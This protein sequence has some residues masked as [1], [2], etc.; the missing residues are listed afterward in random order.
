MTIEVNVPDIG[1]F[2]DV[3]VV[4]ILVKVGDMISVED[5]IIELESDKAT[6]EVPSPVAGKVV[7]INVAEGDNVSEGSLLM[8]VESQVT[9]GAIEAPAPVADP[10]PS[11]PEAAAAPATLT[12]A[13]AVTD[14]GPGKAHASPSVRAFARQLEI[15]LS[16]VNGSGR[17]GRILREDITTFL[18]SST[19]AAAAA[20][21][22]IQ[23]DMG[24]PPIPAV[25]FSKFGPIEDIEMPRIKKLSG[26]A[27]HRSWLNI[28]HVTHNEEADITELDDYRR[29][30]D[31]AAKTEGYRVTL[32]S[33][34]VKASVSALKQHWEVNSSIHSDGDKLIK[35]H[36]HNIGFAADTPTGLV[37]PVIKNADRK[38]IIE[39]SNEL[40][41]LSLKAREGKLKGP[42]M[43]GATFTI[44]SLG[45]IGGTSFT[46]I[47][48]APEVAI[49][50]L[51]RSKMAPVWNGEEFVPR[52]MQPLSLSYDHRA[53]D[54]ALA[55]RFCAT[56]KHLLGDVRRLML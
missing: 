35:K 14:A 25:D 4:T 43:S 24:I 7:E 20:A 28:P 55:A 9:A 56:L 48:N 31:D 54:G 16:K 13:T 50:G 45:G 38:G 23:D 11:A 34:I 51:T 21:G 26:P 15:D 37:V 32:L 46:P 22:G 49:L 12:A 30:L 27:L 29:E 6:L 17:K 19:A 39:I 53:V 2:H 1:D 18:K 8:L 5:P 42:D 33:F 10:T 41:D 36:F 44:S 3:P 40:G 47:V 52:K